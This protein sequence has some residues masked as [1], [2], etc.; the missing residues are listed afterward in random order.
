MQMA[1]TRHD[2]DGQVVDIRPAHED[3]GYL[4]GP[5]QLSRASSRD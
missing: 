2:S 4:H 1:W 5:E 3:G